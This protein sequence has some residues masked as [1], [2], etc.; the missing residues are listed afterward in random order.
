[1]KSGKILTWTIVIVLVIIIVLTAMTVFGSKKAATYNVAQVYITSWNLD[2]ND[3][4]LVDVQFKIYLDLDD[5]G[6]FEVNK[7]SEMFNSTSFELA[8]FHLGGPIDT[9]I[10]K[11]NFKIE[12]II[13][14][15]G[16]SQMMRYTNDG[17]NPVNEG[18][19]ELDISDSWSYESTVGEAGVDCAISYAYYIS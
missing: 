12:V 17:T 14:V 11:F 10:D 6:V 5:D 1:M 15:A 9:Q 4:S 16:A 13:N 19:N 18:R 8:P 3:T 7:S 2:A